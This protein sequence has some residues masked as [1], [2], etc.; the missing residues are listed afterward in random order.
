VPFPPKTNSDA[1]VNTAAALVQTDGLAALSMRTLALRLGVRAS[2][3][4]RHFPDRGAIETALAQRAAEQMLLAMES[5]AAETDGER[6][7]FNAARKYLDYA[8]ANPALYNLLMATNDS[9]SRPVW[10]L[11]LRL[12]S[13]ATNSPVDEAGATA[14]WSFLHGFVA[15]EQKGHLGMT[16]SKLTFVRGTQALVRGL[17][18]AKS[19]ATT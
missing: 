8:A 14:F 18:G 13:H 6:A 11:L 3:L 5:A 1:I 4:Y 15:L 9:V 19:A 12:V 7:L 10:E 2:S 17:S 16:P